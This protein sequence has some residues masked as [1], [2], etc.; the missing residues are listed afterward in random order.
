[1]GIG[2]RVQH[3]GWVGLI[4]PLLLTIGSTFAAG[5]L[6]VTL[7]IAAVIAATWVFSR[8]EIGT[9]K[10]WKSVVAFCVFVVIALGIFVLG[11]R[12][13]ASRS[14]HNVAQNS[15]PSSQEPQQPP[16]S[17]PQTAP[18]RS[19]TSPKPAATKGRKN[20]GKIETGD[21][22]QGCGAIQ[23]GGDSNQANVNCGP[24]P[25]KL[26]YSFQ[27]LNSGEQGAFSFDPAKCPVRTHI[28]I[29]PN[30][31]VPPPVRV[32]L[33]FDY[34]VSE[35]ATTI[36][37]VGAMM[38]GGPFTVGLHAISSPISPG[39]GPHNPLI[40]EV[41]SDVPVRLTGEPRLVN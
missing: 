24:P 1:M 16:P 22:K 34:P 28:R 20:Q 23:I 5:A 10:A 41:C 40:V 26:E 12:F 19:P 21:I 8:T 27:T 11:R 7:L 18:P 13:D 14:Y 9:G 3:P 17:V 6:R 38:G 30:Q 15:P 33:D 36:E 35:I 29:V 2:R 25:L 4:L 31:S 37:N 39:I 32:A